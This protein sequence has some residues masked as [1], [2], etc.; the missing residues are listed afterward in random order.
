MFAPVA[1]DN[2]SFPESA[3][4]STLDAIPESF[5]AFQA[6]NNLNYTTASTYTTESFATAFPSQVARWGY[7]PNGKILGRGE[8][9]TGAYIW[10]VN[11]NTLSAAFLV[12]GPGTLRNIVWENTTNSWVCCGS[13]NFTK[14][15]LNTNALTNIAVPTNIGTQYAAVVAY[16]G[17]AYGLPLTSVTANTGVAIFDLIGNTATTSS[18]KVGTTGGFWGAVLTSVGTIYFVRETGATTTIFEYD[19]V[20]DT[21]TNFG[22]LAGT[23]G[24]GPVNLPNGNVFIPGLGTNQTSYIINPVNKSIQTITTAGFGY[25]TGICIGQ[26][27]HPYGISSQATGDNGI[28]GFNTSTNAGYLTQYVVQRPSSGGRGFQDMFSLPDG[29][30]IAMPGQNNSGRLVYYSYL[31]N[32]NNNTFPGIGAANPIMSNGKGL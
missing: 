30:L 4:L 14:V 27:G 9:S 26:N 1:V 13:T 20:T 28:W 10:D 6:Y 29:R 12:A 22:N 18:V 8:T 2:I 23:V 31:S 19:P 11:T 24:Y 25:L 21:G 5:E 3:S 15:D 32:P 17:K 7:A 16:G